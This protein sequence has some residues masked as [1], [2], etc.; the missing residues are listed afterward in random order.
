MLLNTCVFLLYL[1]EPADCWSSNPPPPPPPICSRGSTA[2]RGDSLF[3][4]IFHFN[5]KPKWQKNK[6]TCHCLNLV[7]LHIVICY[8]HAHCVSRVPVHLEVMICCL[9]SNV[10]HLMLTMNNNAV[11]HVTLKL[12]LLWVWYRPWP[13]CGV[14][15]VVQ[16]S[17]KV[18][19]T[20]LCKWGGRSQWT[21]G[22]LFRTVKGILSMVHLITCIN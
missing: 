22:T 12:Q 15:E 7:Q 8:H 2:K 1:Q 16:L 13:C 9:H 18:V 14:S 3:I 20:V 10:S 19:H 21:L 6:Q 5:F 11:T 17:Y 4:F